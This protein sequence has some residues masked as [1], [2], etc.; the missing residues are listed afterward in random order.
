MYLSSALIL[1]LLAAGGA[2]PDPAARP[3]QAQ[4]GQTQ[5]GSGQKPGGQSP[6]P[7]STPPADAPQAAADDEE[8]TGWVGFIDVGVR[9]TSIDG[10]P[11]R[12][13]RYRDLGDGLFMESLR[14]SREASGWIFDLAGDH[15]GRRDQRIAGTAVDP[16]RFSA[17]FM[18]DQIPMILS[19]STRTLFTGV[20][21]GTLSIDDAIQ[22]QVQATPSSLAALFSQFG[23]TFDTKTRRHIA[24]G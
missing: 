3:D 7:A 23:R 14:L 6:K 2:A 15:V 13:E 11:S 19:R 21:T 8:N 1:A 20:D 5:T 18:W 4:S 24:D 16:G 22:T 10:D 17:T 9:G 12:F